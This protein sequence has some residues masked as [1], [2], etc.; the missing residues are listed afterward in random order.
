[1]SVVKFGQAAATCS[2]PAAAVSDGFR[3]HGETRM[4]VDCEFNDFGGAL[5]SMALVGEDG[6]EWYA[7]LG[8]ANPT[9]WV[10]EHVMPVLRVPAVTRA[11]AQISLSVF[12]R[13]YDRVRVIADWPEDLAHFCQ[14]LI[15]G[16]GM[17]LDT[18]VLSFAIDRGLDTQSPIPHNA[19]SDARANACFHLERPD[20]RFS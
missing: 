17:R 10:A 5:I 3:V 2:S 6:R 11:E 13:R 12:L 1:M 18:P 15:T 14:F 19:L 16:P 7:S 20:W 4:W 9:P 8:C